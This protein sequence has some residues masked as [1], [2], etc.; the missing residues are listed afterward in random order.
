MFS[1]L[2]KPKQALS[3][4]R[5][6]REAK[7]RGV[8]VE[9]LPTELVA[10]FLLPKTRPE[11]FGLVPDAD[12]TADPP[13]EDPALEAVRADV[14][15]GHWENAA[16]LTAASYGTW[17][18][19]QRIAWA[20]A[21]LAAK[22]DAWL[23]T[24]HTARPNDPH[25]SVVHALS[26]VSLAWDIRGSARATDTTHA[27]FE[28][29]HRTLAEA[30][31]AARAAAAVLPDDPTPWSTL[32]TTARGLGAS[33]DDFRTLWSELVARDP[34]HH[35]GHQQALQYWCA[36]WRGS[37]E[38]ALGFA[39]DAADTSPRFAAL[40]LQA[41]L[42]AEDTD[43]SLWKTPEVGRALEV[44]LE[45]LADEGADTVAV[46]DDRGYA[47]LALLRLRRF[48]EAVAQFRVLGGYADAAPWNYFEMPVL[49]FLSLRGDA[50]KGASRAARV[51]RSGR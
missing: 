22:D 32:I 34:L 4:I 19:R 14:R 43:P 47:I 3:V 25:R 50:M 48:D 29:F 40:P 6:M 24:W 45:R 12:V 51:G 15:A 49:S 21:D 5:L 13:V 36:K 8:E 30:R 39:L 10:A 35:D 26:L 37:N 7:R 41:A 38:M 23:T 20:L 16:D 33:H 42:E 46:R 9:E 2:F 1:L 27:Q 28:G 17:D 18:R 31:D 44:L 11:R